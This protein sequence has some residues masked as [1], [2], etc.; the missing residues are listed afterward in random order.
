MSLLT[1]LL[2]AA[3]ESAH[4]CVNVVGVAGVSGFRASPLAVVLM[5]QQTE[6]RRISTSSVFVWGTFDTARRR[7]LH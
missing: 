7:G 3:A 6:W 1:I 5:R 4:V 2:Q